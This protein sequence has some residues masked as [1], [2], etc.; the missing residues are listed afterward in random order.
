[1]EKYLAGKVALVTGSSRGL[2]L[3]FARG[4]AEAGADVIVTDRTDAS[5]ARFGEEASGTAVAE[6]F[7]A[8]GVRSKFYAADLR[9]PK[10]VKKMVEDA[11]A[12]FGQIDILVNNAGGDIG[13]TTP[14]PVVNNCLDIL[15]EDIASVVE[16]NFTSLLYVSKYVGQHMRERKTGK[17]VNVGSVAAHLSV[18]EGII[19]AAAKYAIEHYTLCLAE[20]LRHYDI[21]VNCI[22]PYGTK[23]ARFF[24]TRP[25]PN[26][27]GRSRLQRFAEIQD[28][29]D[30]V[31]FMVGPNSE[32]LTGET[33]IFR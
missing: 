6:K 19:Y 22:A 28:M 5:A 7:R 11:I 14:R 29:V 15:D 26:E 18:K 27:E 25:A 16:R 33:I 31:M 20:E 3:A 10:A 24:A 12:D 32:R 8:M 30:M 23:T 17:I 9:C 4:M 13:E 1:M 2:G 21:N